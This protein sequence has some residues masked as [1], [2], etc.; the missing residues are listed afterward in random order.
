MTKA[1]FRLKWLKEYNVF[2]FSIETGHSDSRF[3][4]TLNQTKKLRRALKNNEGIVFK[5]E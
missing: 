2:E 5:D 3:H 1:W 4:I